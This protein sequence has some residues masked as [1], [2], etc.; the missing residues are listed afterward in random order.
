MFNKLDGRKIANS[1][2]HVGPK[3]TIIWNNGLA[4]EEGTTISVV[5]QYH[6]RCS[7]Q[8][9]TVIWLTWVLYQGDIEVDSWCNPQQGISWTWC[10][11]LSGQIAWAHQTFQCLL[12]GLIGSLH[13]TKD[14][15]FNFFHG[16]TCHPVLY[17][18][19][20]ADLGKIKDK[21]AQTKYGFHYLYV[22]IKHNLSG[23]QCA[24]LEREL[25]VSIKKI[26]LRWRLTCGEGWRLPHL[27]DTDILT[28]KPFQNFA[29]P[30]SPEWG[31]IWIFV[32]YTSIREI[33]KEL[34]W[35]V[36]HTSKKTNTDS[37][38]FTKYPFSFYKSPINSFL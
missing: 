37:L 20:S 38:S 8:G 10:W 11:F 31:W 16:V 23:F 34:K 5:P 28:L 36:R 25:Q 30:S 3:H 33:E 29:F 18:C 24:M 19:T 1:K 2:H 27:C 12:W 17:V 15:P 14:K 7:L 4:Q 13:H 26:P 35:I 6:H 9:E 22:H 21:E 32:S